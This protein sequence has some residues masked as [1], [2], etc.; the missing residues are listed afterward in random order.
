MTRS[1]ATEWEDLGKVWRRE[2][3]VHVEAERIARRVR[4]H[5]RM[6]WL[7]SLSEIGLLLGLAMMSRWY[8]GQSVTAAKIIV[9]VIV[10]ILNLGF[11]AF[12]IWN[13]RGTWRAD[14]ATTVAYLELTARRAQS[15]VRAARF[16]AVAALFQGAAVVALIWV[17]SA[18]GGQFDSRR[19]LVASGLAT[20][21]AAGYGAWSLWYQRV[22]RREL[23]AVAA[24]RRLLDLP[25]G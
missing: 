18:V 16:A 1:I 15:K 12:A 11:E 24:A 7:V 22:G 19:V 5:T 17:Q 25:E 20:V 21:L 6:M 4:A 3:P 8:L 23:Q 9:L 2:Q 10:W 13:R 14:S